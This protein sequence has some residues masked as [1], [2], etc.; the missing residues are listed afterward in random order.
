MQQTPRPGPG[1]ALARHGGEGLDDAFGADMAHHAK[2]LG[3]VTPGLVETWRARHGQNFRT[4]IWIGPS[5]R[6]WM[7]WST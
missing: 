7:N 2:L 1:E 3:E 5:A 6:P 4:C